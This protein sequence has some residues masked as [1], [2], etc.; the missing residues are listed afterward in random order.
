MITNMIPRL[1][2]NVETLPNASISKLFICG[3]L[4]LW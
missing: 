2:N 3:G 4:Y 1:K